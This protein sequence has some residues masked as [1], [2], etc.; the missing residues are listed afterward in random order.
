[1][2]ALAS[3]SCVPA[4]YP[5]SPSPSAGLRSHLKWNARSTLDSGKCQTR[6]VES[7][8]PTASKLTTPKDM[9]RRLLE[10]RALLHSCRFKSV[11]T[12]VPN[13]HQIRGR[14]L[15]WPTLHIMTG[16]TCA[17]YGWGR[18]DHSR[19]TACADRRAGR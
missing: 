11:P 5:T 8:E 2:A 3:H 7:A 15:N 13:L 16:P 17:R 19:L 6:V 9:L 18:P 12:S 14:A 1:M 4:S 10:A